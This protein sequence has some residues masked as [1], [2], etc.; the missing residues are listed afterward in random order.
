MRPSSD[1]FHIVYRLF[2]DEGYIHFVLKMTSTTLLD[3]VTLEER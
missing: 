2:N 3:L 1:C